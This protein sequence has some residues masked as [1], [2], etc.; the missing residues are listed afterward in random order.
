MCVCVSAYVVYVN[1]MRGDY[2][3]EH[4]RVTHT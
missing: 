3:L 1:A 4:A 2:R